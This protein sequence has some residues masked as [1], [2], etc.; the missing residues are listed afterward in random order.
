[1]LSYVSKLLTVNYVWQFIHVHIFY[2]RAIRLLQLPHAPQQKV[3]ENY[4]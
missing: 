3:K 1:M 4:Y 2:Y